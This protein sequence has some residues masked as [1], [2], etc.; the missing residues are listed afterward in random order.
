MNDYKCVVTGGSG[1]IGSHVMDALRLRGCDVLNVDIAE[2]VFQADIS[3]LESVTQVFGDLRPDFV[4]HLAAI[5]NARLALEDPC[6]AV[7]INKIGRA[8]CRERVFRA[9]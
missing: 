7:E 4:F 2:E 8:S 5:S 3:N 1:Y 9:V 6:K